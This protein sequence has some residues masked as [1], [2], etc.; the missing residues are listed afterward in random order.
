MSSA[1]ISLQVVYLLLNISTYYRCILSTVDIRGAFLNTEF[2][3][4][5]SPIYLKTNKDVVPHWVEQDPNTVTYVSSTGEQILLLD[6]FLYGLK[7]SPLNFQ[8]RLS[9]TLIDV[10]YI[11]KRITS[12]FN[13]MYTFRCITDIFQLQDTCAR[14]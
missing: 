10:D 12:G 5:D 4:A 7:Q 11:Y 8:L 9:C 6:R 13:Y 2:T 3:P 14:V 1:T